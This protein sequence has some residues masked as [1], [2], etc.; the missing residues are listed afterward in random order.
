[1]NTPDNFTGP[2]N[3]GNPEEFTILELAKLIVELTNSNS[4]IVFKP[5]PKDDPMRRQ[6]DISLAKEKLGWAPRIKLR[7]GLVK[8]IEYFDKLIIQNS[9]KVDSNGRK[10]MGIYRIL[11]KPKIY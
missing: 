4:K 2:I 3:L 11:E 10:P 8:T 6:P 5:L 9:Q 1:M 7:E